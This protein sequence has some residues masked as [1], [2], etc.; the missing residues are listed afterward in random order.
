[1]KLLEKT[2]CVLILLFSPLVLLYIILLSLITCWT[3]N[4]EYEGGD[5]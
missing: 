1:M 2:I 4:R 3:E 5:A